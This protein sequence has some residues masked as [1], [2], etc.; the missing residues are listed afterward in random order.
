[1]KIFQLLQKKKRVLFIFGI[2]FFI[3]LFLRTWQLGAY[4]VG[5]HSDEAWLTY[6]SWTLLNDGTNIYGDKWPI[7]VDM[8]GDYVSALPSY[9]TIP[10]VAVFGLDVVALRF[11]TGIFSVLTLIVSTLLVYMLTRKTQIALGFAVLFA[12]SP[13][14]VL[15][16]RASS[17]V[18][19]DA[20]WLLSFCVA[21]FTFIQRLFGDKEK[22]T[23]K[24][25][26]LPLSILGVYLLS[27]VAYFTYF[28]SRLL[29]IPLGIGLLGFAYFTYRPTIKKLFISALPLLMYCIFPFALLMFSPLALGRFQQTTVLNSQLV[30]AKIFNTISRSGQAGM[31]VWATRLLYNK[32][33]TNIQVAFEHYVTLFSPEVLLFQTAPPERYYVPNSGVV[34]PIE[35]LGLIIAV[36][37]VFIG[38]N[39]KEDSRLRLVTFWVLVALLF[40]AVPSGITVDDFPNLQRAVIMTPFLQM[41]AAIGWWVVFSRFTRSFILQN[42]NKKFSSSFVFSVLLGV[43]SIPW[44]ISLGVG[45][46]VHAP[47]ESPFFR[48]VAAEDMSR[49]INAEAPSAKMLIENRE[50]IFLY[51]YFFAEEKLTDQTIQKDGAYFVDD[52]QINNRLFYNNLCGTETLFT[53]EYEYAIVYTTFSDCERPWWMEEVYTSYYTDG[54]P[55]FVVWK[56]QL[57]SQKMY[58]ELWSSALHAEDSAKQKN[59]LKEAMAAEKSGPN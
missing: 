37:F 11:T 43:V 57:E 28:T 3:A 35:Y 51:P 22:N 33:T 36:G 46:V 56:P 29:I 55:G 18:I 20:F 5:M 6:N 40:A 19:I 30:E 1:M 49:W 12:L 42:G 27:V 13:W 41:A 47:F 50:T 58:R 39:S 24:K 32:V 17:G 10:A 54:T 26:Y 9:F 7:T 23:F 21:F 8:F 4:P 52:F 59:I 31:P 16:S 25:K 45:L 53:E 34:T 15:Y 48:N 2:I 14:N 38:S 44:I